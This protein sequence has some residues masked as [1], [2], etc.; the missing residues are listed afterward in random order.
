MAPGFKGWGAVPHDFQPKTKRRPP[1][2]ENRRPGMAGGG[3]RRERE[4]LGVYS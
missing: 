3:G 1:G 4:R 2:N